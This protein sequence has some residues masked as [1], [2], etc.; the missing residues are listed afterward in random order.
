[1]AGKGAAKKANKGLGYKSKGRVKNG[2]PADKRLRQ[3]KSK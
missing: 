1:M 2:P 3:N